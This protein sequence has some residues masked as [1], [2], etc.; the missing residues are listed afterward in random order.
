M[1]KLEA[2]LKKY[3]QI[4][5]MIIFGSAVKGK[6]LPKDIDMAVIVKEKDFD[7]LKKLK[8]EL[9]QEKMHIELVSSA[10]LLK[11]RL[12]LS[13]LTEG[14]S[15]EKKDFLNRILGLKPVKLFIYNLKGFDRSKKALFSMALTKTIK[16]I[17]GNRI[18]P[19]AVMMP[20]DKSGYFNEFLESWK[21]KY[22][23]SEWTMF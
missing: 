10:S 7:L 15:V 20:I 16:K 11:N 12:S 3:N 14:Y 2:L 4:E 6:E 8:N 17:K 5:D 21:I 9:K 13:L 18:A 22:Q 1:K 23:T 19:G